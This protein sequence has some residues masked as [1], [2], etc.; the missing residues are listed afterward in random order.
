MVNLFRR[1]VKTSLVLQVKGP[2]F[3]YDL[4]FPRNIFNQIPQYQISR[5]SVQ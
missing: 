5:Q 2:K 1:E 3:L 4:Y